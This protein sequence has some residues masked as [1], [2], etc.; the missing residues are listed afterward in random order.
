MYIKTETTEPINT[1]PR[2]V[3]FCILLSWLVYL[4]V[5]F[6]VL[7]LSLSMEGPGFFDLLLVS[8]VHLSHLVTMIVITRKAIINRNALLALV[9]PIASGVVLFLFFQ[10]VSVFL[11][12]S[13]YTKDT[14]PKPT[15]TIFICS[16]DAYI[17][18]NDKHGEVALKRIV[19]QNGNGI[20]V[21]YLGQVKNNTI[22]NLNSV[23]KDNEEVMNML[24]GCRNVD[25]KSLSELYT[26]IF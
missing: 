11:T 4:P 17:D 14:N 22:L 2:S 24:R 1:I 7:R 10:I 18:T 20:S 13:V 3:Q 21:T 8:V 15:K 16:N 12:Y 9:S 19:T 26:L 23:Y 6:I 5:A 25:N